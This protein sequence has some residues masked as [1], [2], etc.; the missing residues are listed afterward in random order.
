MQQ[1]T[2][3]INILSGIVVSIVLTGCAVMSPQQVR[4]RVG[5]MTTFEVCLAAEAKM[6]RKTF[7]LGPEMINAVFERLREQTIDCSGQRPEII[8][9]LIRALRDEEKRNERNRFYFGFG[10]SG[11]R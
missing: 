3:R 7:A 10:L 9:F 4:D 11:G 5:E 8:Q 6:D 1:D 2:R